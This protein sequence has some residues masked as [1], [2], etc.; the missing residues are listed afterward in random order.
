MVVG[1][2]GWTVSHPDRPDS[3]AVTPLW[4]DSIESLRVSRY[5]DRAYH[6]AS[7]PSFARACFVDRVISLWSTPADLPPET[8]EHFLADQVFPRILA[9]Q[10]EFV[11]HAGA[12]V[13]DGRAM[14]FL[15]PSGRGK[16]TLTASL[17]RQG[18]VLLGD[19]ALI[20]AP[21]HSV[22]AVYPSL[23]LLPDSLAHLFPAGPPT[24]DVAH[25]SAKQSLPV[26]EGGSA[27]LTA[28]FF[29]GEPGDAISLRR[30]SIAEICIGL[31]SNSFALDP[32]DPADAK[33]KLAMASTLAAALPAWELSYPRDYARLPEVH[34]AIR[35]QMTRTEP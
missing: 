9:H 23:R 31:I 21:D 26:A 18:A 5:A 14:A 20:V 16:S 17:E 13:E 25:Y 22:R 2:K 15:G 1:A 27:P 6:L 10:G 12:V 24:R 8:L 4:T 11:L 34:A 19:D 7:P 29:L 32:T 28:L 3:S 33:R 35:A 30:M